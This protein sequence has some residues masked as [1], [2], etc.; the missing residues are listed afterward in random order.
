M[1]LLTNLFYSAKKKLQG[2][3]DGENET[4]RDSLNSIVASKDS[5]SDEEISTK[6]D[7]LKSTC[8]L[9]PDSEE[10]TL[11]ER[12]LEDLKIVKNQDTEIAQKAVDKI[13]NL[14]EKLDSKASEEPTTEPATDEGKTVEEKKEVSEPAKDD[15]NINANGNTVS[16]ANTGAN[17]G[18][19]K[20]E[21]KTVEE[22]KEETSE[23]S[24]DSNET[25]DEGKFSQEDLEQIWQ[26]IKK[27]LE[28][29][30]ATTDGDETEGEGKSESEEKEK[31]VSDHAPKINV[32]ITKDKAGKVDAL[33]DI[34]NKMFNVR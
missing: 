25:K 18:V 11:L 28:E 30:T 4:F 26:F 8:S 17:N 23:K 16:A 29:E 34:F 9:L 15:L 14:F 32:K 13:A 12:Y 31:T 27:K 2:V 1:K 6:V 5:L 21:G 33:N 24:T 20:D 7:E 3:K 10:K 22:K 19:A